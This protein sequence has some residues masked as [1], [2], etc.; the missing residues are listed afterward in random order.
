MADTLVTGPTP[1][2]VPPRLPRC[3]RLAAHAAALTLVPS[4]LWR[5]AIALGWNSGFTEDFLRPENFP[6]AG[7]FYL[8]GLSLL[9]EALGL[10][11]LG[12]VHQWGE[13]LPHWVPALGGRR[14]P[15][16]AAVIPASLGAAL[17]TLITI[18]GAFSWNDADNMGGAGSPD[19]SHY[20]LMTACYMPLLAWGPL[21]AV[22]TVAYYRRRRGGR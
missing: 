11:T 18:T 3:V 13:E 6:G 7:S 15:V 14:I 19:G 12:L 5:T 2:T 4:G 20:W 21:L 8:I 9:T 16:M 10:L 22:V 1:V 17:V